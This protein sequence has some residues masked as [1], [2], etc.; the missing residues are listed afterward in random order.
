MEAEA[1]RAA[2]V[3]AATNA[4]TVPTT[5]LAVALTDDD[6]EAIEAYWPSP[7]LGS[8]QKVLVDD[9][10]LSSIH[11]D[12]SLRVVA[13]QDLL[14]I[15]GLHGN[16]DSLGWLL[17][18]FGNFNNVPLT[19]RSWRVAPPDALHHTSMADFVFRAQRHFFHPL[20]TVLTGIRVVLSLDI[21]YA[22]GAPLHVAVELLDSARVLIYRPA[23]RVLL[24]LLSRAAASSPLA[25]GR[26]A[27]A[28]ARRRPSAATPPGSRPARAWA[29]RRRHARRRRGRLRWA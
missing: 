10:L 3:K 17:T 13:P 18:L 15:L 25:R 29:A 28:G 26:S 14:R 20:A 4:L 19:L 23:V 9:L 27:A 5:S 1:A 12:L 16:A 11:L 8:S 24:R 6:E 22:L 7:A 2:K 21:F